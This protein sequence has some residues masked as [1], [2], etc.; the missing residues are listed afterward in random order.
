ML[1]VSVDTLYFTFMSYLN[2][3]SWCWGWLGKDVR[4]VLPSCAVNKIRRVCWIQVPNPVGQEG[5]EAQTSQPSAMNI[6]QWLREV[7]STKLFNELGDPGVVV[8]VDESVFTHKPK[9][10]NSCIHNYT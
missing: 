3:T 8:Q 10:Y 5:K 4:V 7:C 1:C 9:V 2:L 6:Y